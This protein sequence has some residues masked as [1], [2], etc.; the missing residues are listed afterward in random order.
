[1]K[2]LIVILLL[3]ALAMS[4]QVMS[5]QAQDVREAARQAAEA[6]AT[7]ESRAAAAEAARLADRGQLLAD[8]ER[9]EA[10]KARLESELTAI[11]A[12]LAAQEERRL[13]LTETWSQSELQF[14]EI[15]GNVR[16][17]AKEVE[18][19]LHRSSL[20]AGH[21]E[22]LDGVRKLV[23]PGY[24]PGIDDISGMASVI[25]DEIRL[26]GQVALREGV[27][28]GRDGQETR[29]DI[30]TLGKFTAAYR[31][32]AEIGYLNYAAESSR[33]IALAN[34]PRGGLG[35]DLSGYFNGE[36]AEVPI[37][38]SGGGAL[39]QVSQQESVWEHLQSGGPIVWP[40]LALAA[41]ALLIVIYKFV[42]LQAVH[43]SASK[44]TT[45]VSEL[46][47]AGDWKGAAQ[48]LEARRGSPLGHVLSAGLAVRHEDR[49]VQ[50]SVLQEA[51]LN[52]LPK[53]ER[54]MAVLAVLGAVAPLLGLLGTVTGMIDTFKVIT[55]YGT[56]DPK[57]MSGG[58]SEALITTELGLMVAIPIMLFHTFLSRRVESIVG[59]MEERSV[60]LCN[61]FQKNDG[62]LKLVA[63]GGA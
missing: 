15:S 62:K 45:R 61:I 17:A 49:Q 21:P 25:F 34:L 19:L 26:S 16:L 56:G 28:V 44:I 18:T 30:L 47:E 59:D 39:R 20:T 53:V 42:Y 36:S 38:I 8:V 41:I 12:R 29:G 13:K 46:A 7:A 22:R 51:I 3:T 58:I 52:Q 24:F 5:A 43:G 6:R 55:I 37:D 9:F 32:P 60:Q 27:F 35:R 40:I 57:L 4:A 14:K 23:E 63:S 48:V 31:T 11:Q 1:M 2:R 33:F 54:G 10:E 50:E